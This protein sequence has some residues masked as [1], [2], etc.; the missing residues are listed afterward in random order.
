[1]KIFVGSLAALMTAGSLAWAGG[2]VVVAP[3]RINIIQV[4][5]DLVERHGVTLVSYQGEAATAKPLLHVWNGKA[6]DYVALE[7]F[8][9]GAFLPAKPSQTLV[10]GD[11]KL[12]PEALAPMSAWAGKQVKLANLATPELLNGVGTALKFR[13]EDWKWFATRYN[14]K[15]EDLNA[16]V[17]KG[18]VY[19]HKIG[20]PIMLR[21]EGPLSTTTSTPPPAILETTE[22][23]KAD[24][25]KPAD[26]PAAETPAVK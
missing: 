24:A 22:P 17:R 9:S 25:E 12:V 1:M 16:E 20:K 21:R 4:G 15:T 18:S 5:M 7:A 10:I 8:Q 3:A 13:A 23:K 19:D 6:W 2:T 26:K 14:M 11:E